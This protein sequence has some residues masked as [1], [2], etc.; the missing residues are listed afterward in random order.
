MGFGRCPWFTASFLIGRSGPLAFAQRTK[1]SAVAGGARLT[2]EGG[3]TM[4][5]KHCIHGANSVPRRLPFLRV[6]R[7][8]ANGVLLMRAV[9]HGNWICKRCSRP[10]PCGR[11]RCV[12]CGQRRES[13]P[14]RRLSVLCAEVRRVSA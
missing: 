5:W 10:N 14:A 3:S 2:H 11:S 13:G 8:E 6:V 1:A 9:K 4:T 7:T 12:A